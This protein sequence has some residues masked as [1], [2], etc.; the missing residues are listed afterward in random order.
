MSHQNYNITYLGGKLEQDATEQHK[1][2]VS[3]K[4]QHAEIDQEIEQKIVDLNAAQQKSITLKD[5]IETHSIRILKKEEALAKV[6]AT[7]HILQEETEEIRKQI[8]KERQQ[9][10]E[11]IKFYENKMALIATKLQNGPKF[12]D[13]KNTAVDIA[14]LQEETCAISKE[15]TTVEEELNSCHMKYQSLFNE[16]LDNP[17]TTEGDILELSAI[18]SIISELAE[19][20]KLYNSK[21]QT[22]QEEL[23]NLS[24]VLTVLEADIQELKQGH[25]IVQ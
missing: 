12:Y 17:D 3:L 2:L 10:I 21:E 11:D 5:D 1:A 20:N 24:R 15:L 22:L 13:S 25:N 7:L 19:E 23:K 16:S 14:S 4:Q 9:Q 6:E 18:K 8:K